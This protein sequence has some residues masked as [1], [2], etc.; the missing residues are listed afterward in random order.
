MKWFWVAAF[1]LSEIS[2]A[3]PN[4]LGITGAFTIEELIE[5]FRGVLRVKVL[6]MEDSL[7]V[8]KNGPTAI[9]LHNGESECSHIR[10]DDSSP[11]PLAQIAFAVTKTSSSLE[12]SVVYWGCDQQIALRETFRIS[13]SG[14]YKESSATEIFRGARSFKFNEPWETWL[15]TLA[16]RTGKTVLHI[17]ATQ[18]IE[19]I[20]TSFLIDGKLSLLVVESKLDKQVTYDF[21]GYQISYEYR[22]G[23]SR[24]SAKSTYTGRLQSFVRLDSLGNPQ[25]FINGAMTSKSS[26]QSNMRETSFTSLET[27]K[28]W[29][30]ASL[31]FLPKTKFT[32]SGSKG[33]RLLDELRRNY[34]RLTTNTEIE[35][36]KLEIQKLIKDMEDGLIQVIDNRP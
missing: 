23:K 21:S 16:D 20:R 2:L 24:T 10:E 14:N 30:N 8:R 19:S 22:F 29:L 15:Y 18:D 25:F 13:G 1:I 35:R 32:A 3:Q 11:A 7:L 31:S 9:Y 12:E 33:S 36:V 6:Q 17:N 4:K 27:I 34:Q 26:F 28:T 5:E